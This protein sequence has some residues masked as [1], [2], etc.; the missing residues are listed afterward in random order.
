MIP[1]FPGDRATSPR[2]GTFPR[3]PLAKLDCGAHCFAG[4]TEGCRGGRAWRD[5]AAA[6][7]RVAL[8]RAVP[9]SAAA[10]GR[11]ALGRAVPPRGHT[12]TDFVLKIQ[13]DMMKI[14]LAD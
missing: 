12:N 3:P 6:G 2:E 1:R 8:G 13:S 11:V 7:G 5:R 14:T 4:N 10:G 9:G